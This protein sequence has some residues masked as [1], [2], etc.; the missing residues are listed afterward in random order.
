VQQV[1]ADEAGLAT[2]EQKLVKAKLPVLSR[3]TISPSRM[4]DRFCAEE[5]GE[6]AERLE[7]VPIP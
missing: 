6:C 2:P 1:E 5:S 3:H 7:L 4:T